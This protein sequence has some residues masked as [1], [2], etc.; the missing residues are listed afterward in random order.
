M[1]LPASDSVSTLSTIGSASQYTDARSRFTDARS[2][3]EEAMT[4]ADNMENDEH[5]VAAKAVVMNTEKVNGEH[6]DNAN[7]VVAKK[8]VIDEK[9]DDVK[10]DMVKTEQP[11]AVKQ[12]R[13]YVSKE[14]RIR[15]IQMQKQKE[16]LGLGES[17]ASQRKEGECHEYMCSNHLM[18]VLDLPNW[19][20][21]F[22][23]LCSI[24]CNSCV[25]SG[26]A[27]AKTAVK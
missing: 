5:I 26:T 15:Q 27:T 8:V 16:N 3:F 4:D 10:E 11:T 21:L 12:P 13:A 22:C 7:D 18:E 6:P 20:V 14:E 24:C 9:A 25:S 17:H 23:G 1:S 2:G 19:K